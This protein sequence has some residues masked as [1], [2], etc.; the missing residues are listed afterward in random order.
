MSEQHASARRV[1]PATERVADALRHADARLRGLDPVADLIA[2]AQLPTPEQE[3]WLQLADVATV[4]ITPD[5][6]RLY[7]H[8]RGIR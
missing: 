4:T 8:E 3:R 2:W 6:R 5:I 7:L 1:P